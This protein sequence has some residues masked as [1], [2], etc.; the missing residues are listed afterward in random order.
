VTH[1]RSS[2]GPI[3]RRR[4]RAAFMAG[5]V[6][7]VAALAGAAWWQN[8]PDPEAELRAHHRPL[9]TLERKPAPQLGRGFERWLMIAPGPDT[10]TALWRPG[11]RT[12]ARPWV[13][14]ILGGIGTD[15]RAAALVPDSLPIGVPVLAKRRPN[16]SPDVPNPP[17]ERV[18]ATMKSPLSSQATSCPRKPKM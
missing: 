13:A 3:P 15:D 9:V 16:T 6:F 7:G 18:Q 11:I 12:D 1:A 10:M 14:V 4:S 17:E 5:V 8:P 2:P